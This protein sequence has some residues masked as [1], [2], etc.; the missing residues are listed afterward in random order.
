MK[1]ILRG[2]SCKIPG[3]SLDKAE[4]LEE[5]IDEFFEITRFNLSNIV[6]EY[7]RGQS[8]ACLLEQLVFEFGPMFGEKHLNYML[9]A[10]P[11]LMIL[12]DADKMQRVL[13]NLLRN[14][15]YY[16]FEGSTVEIAAAFKEDAA[17][18]TVVNQGNTIPKEKLGR[19]FEQFYRL[20]TARG[21]N[22][23]GAGLGLPSPERSW[24]CITER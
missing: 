8:A 13:D 12:C 19:I 16:S 7:S 22:S 20:D 11:D 23:G 14:A 21:S 9:H 3:I 6:L 24:S 2:A 10:E 4:R 15:V 5:L 17:V 18:I 1:E